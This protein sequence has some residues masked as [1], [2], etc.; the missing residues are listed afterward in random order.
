MKRNAGAI[1]VVAGF[2]LL[3]I[4]LNF[5]FMTDQPQEETEFNADRSSYRATK[6]GTLGLYTLLEETGYPVTRLEEPY[7]NLPVR[8]DIGTILVISP[9]EWHSPSRDEFDSVIEWVKAG[10]LVVIVDRQI[11]LPDPDLTAKTVVAGPAQEMS[12]SQPTAYTKDVKKIELSL[13][14][15][16]LTLKS[17][18]STVH[19]GDNNG[20]VLADAKIGNGRIVFLTD[21][22]VVANNGVPKADNLTLV[23]NILAQRPAGSIAFDEYHHGHGKESLLGETSTGVMGYFSGT[24]IPWMMAQAGL[25]ILAFLYTRGRRFARPLP[26]RRERRTTNLEFVSSMANI[27][28]LARAS[29]LAMKNIYSEFRRKL[30]KYAGMPPKAETRALS[31]AVA[32]RGKLDAGELESLLERCEKIANGAATGDSELLGLV[33]RVRAIESKLG[34]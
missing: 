12:P 9:P 29:D 25:L 32:R 4:A 16:R 31:T 18:S 8:S 2:F 13:F 10:G 19:I 28:R 21:P 6:F 7:T 33:L 30:C 20:A 1:L 11:D 24:P 22:Y 5:L 17:S 15:S 14:A 26:Q 3:V 27:I 34:L 23:L